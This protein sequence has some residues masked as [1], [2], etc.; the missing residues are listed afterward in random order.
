MTGARQ[1]LGQ[2]DGARAGRG[3]RGYR[4]AGR[5]RRG[6]DRRGG[7]GS[8]RRF[9]PLRCDL[10]RTPCPPIC[11]RSWHG[12]GG[13]GPAGYPGQQRRHHPPRAGAR[14]QRGGLGR[15]DADRSE[16]R[17][18]PS[19]AAARVMAGRAAA[20]SSTSPPCSPSRAGSC[21]PLLHGR[22]E[23]R[24]RAD[25]SAGQR[26]GASGHQRQRHRPRL[27]GHGQHRAAAGRCR[28]QR[29]NPGPHPGRPLGRTR[30]TCKEPPVFLAS[31]ASDYVHGAILAVDGG[32]LA[33]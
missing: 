13:H 27:H 32:W 19:Q 8:G 29:G 23:R 18:L 25:P 4:G 30:R 24:G 7:E 33:R 12:R 2:G 6:R 5:G 21:V 16:G 10:T 3:R 1:G 15:R 14:F 26:V 9:L 31:A 11:R 28:A 22:Q 17:L 20:R